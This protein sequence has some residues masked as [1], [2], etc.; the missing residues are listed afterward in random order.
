LKWAQELVVIGA[1]IAALAVL[2]HFRA[3]VLVLLSGDDRIHGSLLDFLWFGIFKCCGLCSHDWTRI[4]TCWPCC[5][6]SI[7]GANLVRMG[8]AHMGFATT[9]VEISNLVVGDLPY[10]GGQ[11][12]F[13]LHFECSSNP[14]QKTA[15]SENRFPKIVH[16]PEVITLKLRDHFLEQQVRIM[17]CELNLIGSQ[18]LCDITLNAQ[19]IIDWAK[20]SGSQ[21]KRFAM[22]PIDRGRECETPPWIALDFDRPKSDNRNLEHWTGDMATVRTATWDPKNPQTGGYTDLGMTPFKHK[23]KLV[24]SSGNYV[25][26]PEEADLFALHC[27]RTLVVCIY[28]VINLVLTVLVIGWSIFRFYVWSCYK[29]FEQLTIAAH[30]QQPKLAFPMSTFNLQRLADFCKEKLDGTG[31]APGTHVCRPDLTQVEEIC[32]NVPTGQPR[33]TALTGVFQRLLG[34]DLQGVPCAEGVCKFRNQ[35]HQYDL[36]IWGG[37]AILLIWSLCCFRPCANR[38][39]E[40]KRKS[41]R[42]KGQGGDARQASR[43]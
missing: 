15:L 14:P 37:C 4:F 18:E 33:P 34:I 29:H 27:F 41:Y 17:V 7:R 16:F 30:W 38:I 24:D 32:D 43:S 35:I 3:Q 10:D 20:D 2:W 6:A 39:I 5:P 8:G 23:Y 36:V 19:N 1:V 31:T 26:E 28:S 21:T 12:D 25:Q 11:G 40:N 13:Y 22:K 9:T 42:R